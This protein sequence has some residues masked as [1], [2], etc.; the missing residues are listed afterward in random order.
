MALPRG[1][2]HGDTATPLGG[3]LLYD[4][5]GGGVADGRVLRAATLRRLLVVEETKLEAV[6]VLVA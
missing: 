5:R 1:G 2:W 6:T 3:A 4:E